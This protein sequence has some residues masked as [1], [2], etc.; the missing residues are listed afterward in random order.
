MKQYLETYRE[1]EKFK[2]PE[3]LRSEQLSRAA[4]IFQK[5]LA[6]FSYQGIVGDLKERRHAWRTFLVG[7]I[8]PAKRHSLQEMRNAGASED[9]LAQIETIFDGARVIDRALAERL[10]EEFGLETKEQGKERILRE[11]AWQQRMAWLILRHRTMHSLAEIINDFWSSLSRNGDAIIEHDGYM[12]SRKHGIEHLVSAVRILEDAGFEMFRVKEERD[13]EEGTDTEGVRI[14]PD[15]RRFVIA[16][17]VKPSLP[18]REEEGSLEIFHPLPAESEVGEDMHSLVRSVKERKKQNSHVPIFAIRMNV[19]SS[20]ACPKGIAQGTGLLK[21]MSGVAPSILDK[22]S[23]ERL[24]NIETLAK[25]PQSFKP[26]KRRI[27][28]PNK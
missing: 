20:W 15:G 7:T 10:G 22:K 17:Q 9:A 1:S 28:V 2:G 11:A 4:E 8:E 6:E 5:S 21:K 13:V 16:V 26:K 18:E 12:K 14:L 23:Q 24:N 27:Y 3:A 25:A 19:P